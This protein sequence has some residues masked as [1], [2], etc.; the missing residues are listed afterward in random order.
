[1]YIH[2][3]DRQ[4]CMHKS[5][6]TLEDMHTCSIC[7]ASSELSDSSR[8]LMLA[9]WS[10]RALRMPRTVSRTSSSSCPGSNGA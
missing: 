8:K 10:R 7:P 9:L 2:P 6:P 5:I 3:N 1:M 4:M